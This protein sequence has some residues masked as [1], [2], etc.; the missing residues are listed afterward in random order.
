MRLSLLALPAGARQGS[1]RALC[2]GG[3]WPPARKFD[4]GLAPSARYTFCGAERGS[5]GHQFVEC[6]SAFASGEDPGEGMGFPEDVWQHRQALREKGR[7]LGSVEWDVVSSL[8]GLLCSPGGSRK[9][10]GAGF[11]S[12][13]GLGSTARCPRPP[14]VAGASSRF[15]MMGGF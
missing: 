14:D 12:R 7:A 3:L 6:S 10:P 11:G 2:S 15:L 8:Y 5:M 1:M 13:M 4:A 9:V